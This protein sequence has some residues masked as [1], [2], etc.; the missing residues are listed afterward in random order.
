MSSSLWT[1]LGRRGTLLYSPRKR[2]SR[3]AASWASFRISPKC[4]RISLTSSGVGW[5]SGQWWRARCWTRPSN[6]A[7]TRSSCGRWTTLTYWG[8]GLVGRND[9]ATTRLNKTIHWSSVSTETQM[10]DEDS[11]SLIPRPSGELSVGSGAERILSEMTSDALKIHQEGLTKTPEPG[12]LLWEFETGDDVWSSPAI[13]S[14]GTVYV[15]S[16]DHKLYAI[17]TSSS[18]LA[19]SPWPMF[20]QNPQ[21]TGRAPH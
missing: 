13:G 3:T 19:D 7:G 4:P 16:Y 18:G 6:W 14:D 20:G 11:H 5:R 12:T 1:D 2:A 10:P 8:C 21:H 15:G 9:A 17:A